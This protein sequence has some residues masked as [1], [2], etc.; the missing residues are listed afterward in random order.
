VLAVNG[1]FEIQMCTYINWLSLCVAVHV[2]VLLP[3]LAVRLTVVNMMKALLL[4]LLSSCARII[5]FLLLNIFFSIIQLTAKIMCNC[6]YVYMYH[7][8]AVGL[9]V[10]IG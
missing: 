7:V 6:C 1:L 2:H 10:A 4:L 5:I 9:L 8:K 3:G